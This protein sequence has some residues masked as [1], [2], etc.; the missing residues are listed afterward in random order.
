MKKVILTILALVFFYSAFSQ[1]C[2][3]FRNLVG[4]GQFAKPDYDPLTG[5]QTKWF[6]NVTQRYYTSHQT[7]SGTDK[8]AEQDW[9]EKTTNLYMMN[10]G[11]TRVL[12]NGW[13]LS[14]DLPL[15]SGSRKAW[16]PE[17]NTSDSSRHTTR[18]FGINDIR[19]TAYKW[20]WDVTRGTRGNIQV[21]LGMKLP[22]GDYRYSDY[23]FL[24]DSTKVVA[25][26]NPTIQLGDG[27]TGFTV[28]MNAFYALSSSF[29]LYGNLFYLFNPRDV[30]GVSTTYGRTATDLQK[31]ATSD[32]FSVPDSYTARIG[33]NAVVH[34]FTFW[35]GLRMEGSPVHDALGASNGQRRSGKVVS[36]DPGVNYKMKTVT[37]YMFAPFP[38][39]RET[40]QTVP[41]QRLSDYTGKY[42]PSPGG[43]ANWQVFLGVMIKL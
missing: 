9:Q 22:T 12:N 2:I 43:F 10:L 34:D 27:G 6:L 20:L 16:R 32:I 13:A 18:S 40:K 15:S 19:I 35:A 21:G 1:G 7:Y 24:N 38:I 30:N 31:K 37:L 39:F 5:L 4:F 28:E 11:I 33:G 42:V 8:V 36:V 17:H 25:P 23:F 26:V 3:P 29:T 14:I 41:D